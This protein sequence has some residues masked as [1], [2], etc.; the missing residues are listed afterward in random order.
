MSE[1]EIEKQSGRGKER[2]R[3]SD[4]EREEERNRAKSTRRDYGNLET[5]IETWRRRKLEKYTD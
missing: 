2:E 3:E 5:Q 1:G 4:R